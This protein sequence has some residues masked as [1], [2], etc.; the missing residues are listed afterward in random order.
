M[1]DYK[2]GPHADPIQYNQVWI[3]QVPTWTRPVERPSIELPF[4][5]HMLSFLQDADKMTWSQ[6]TLELNFNWKAIPSICATE[7]VI[8]NITRNPDSPSGFTHLTHEIY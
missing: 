5:D 6:V 8:I 3:H 1:F 7:I 2:H 4:Q